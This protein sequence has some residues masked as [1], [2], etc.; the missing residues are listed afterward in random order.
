MGSWFGGRGTVVE[1]AKELIFIAGI[2][3]QKER[4]YVP[5]DNK[6]ERDK[7]THKILYIP[8]NIYYVSM[9]IRRMRIKLF[10]RQLSK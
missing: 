2:D 3:I 8:K 1:M 7:Q 10:F 5:T 9:V 4:S 6:R